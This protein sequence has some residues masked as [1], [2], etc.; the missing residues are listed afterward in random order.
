MQWGFVKSQ[1]P[2]QTYSWSIL[3]DIV[4]SISGFCLVY[5]AQMCANLF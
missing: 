1:N 3:L 4:H 5:T 2:L